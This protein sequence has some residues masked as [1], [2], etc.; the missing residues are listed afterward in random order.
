M[1]LNRTVFATLVGGPRVR[2][3]A[4]MQTLPQ[5]L[6]PTPRKVAWVEALVIPS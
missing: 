4:V 5:L 6:A 1:R 2:E 3:P